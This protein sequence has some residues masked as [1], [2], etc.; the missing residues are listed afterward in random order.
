M[1]YY[2]KLGIKHYVGHDV[3][4]ELHNGVIFEGLL[5]IDQVNED[6]RE[7]GELEA[8]GLRTD[9]HIEAIDLIDIKSIQYAKVASSIE[10]V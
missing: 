7:D 5:D 6:W 4:I 2:R 3:V 8:L 10:A 1:S 9:T